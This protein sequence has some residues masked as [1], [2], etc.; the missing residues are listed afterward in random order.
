MYDWGN[1]QLFWKFEEPALDNRERLTWLVLHYSWWNKSSSSLFRFDSS[2]ATQVVSRT[3]S[4]PLRYHN[5]Q[6]TLVLPKITIFSGLISTLNIIYAKKL[7]ARMFARESSVEGQTSNKI[8]AWK[9][10]VFTFLGRDVILFPQQTIF[11]VVALC[12]DRSWLNRWEVVERIDS[13]T[14]SVSLEH[15]TRS[16]EI[17]FR[18][19]PNNWRKY[20][21]IIETFQLIRAGTN[22]NPIK[23]NY[24]NC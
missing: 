8:S 10:E 1:E 24:D 7:V 18:R 15:L 16:C 21:E 20:F 4:Q 3:G 14:L 23:A 2:C 13:R 22:Q 19:R 5:Q 11:T 12:N 17:E 6:K 9:A